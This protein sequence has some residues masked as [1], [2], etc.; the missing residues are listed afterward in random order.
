MTRYIQQNLNSDVDEKNVISS[1]NS[2][3]IY[4]KHRVVET[5]GSRQMR[6][7]LW[8]TLI[9]P[10]QPKTFAFFDEVRLEKNFVEGYSSVHEAK[11]F[12]FDPS[13]LSALPLE[14]HAGV[15]KVLAASPALTR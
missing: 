11:M 9:L 7:F 15:S 12:H 1:M 14:V 3:S 8:P 2:P 6:H 5:S 4:L 10:R 13:T